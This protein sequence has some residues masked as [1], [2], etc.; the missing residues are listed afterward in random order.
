MKP[1][2]IIGLI[3]L[4]SCTKEHLYAE[5]EEQAIDMKHQLSSI[6]FVN[7]I[8]GYAVGGNIWSSGKIFSTSDAGEHWQLN[9]TSIRQLY[10]IKYEDETLLT[11]GIGEYF[12]QKNRQLNWQM[13]PSPTQEI[14]RSF[15]IMNNSLIFVGGVAFKE[16][17]IV[18]TDTLQNIL[19]TTKTGHELADVTFADEHTVFAVGYG[20]IYRSDDSGLQWQQLPISG[21][22][23][24]AVQFVTSHIGYIIGKTGTIL[25][26]D[27][28]GQNWK[29]LRDGAS[30][31]ISDKPFS[32]LHFITPEN[33]FVVGENG[34]CWYTM[35]GGKNWFDI[36]DLPKYDF[37]DI[38]VQGRFAWL[39]S[40]E[41]KIIRFQF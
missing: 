19:H 21:D 12:W 11:C 7:T 33:G 29:T 38:A 16:G 34:L 3:F 20:A 14:Y 40:K 32:N 25:R 5:W 1:L 9:E 13:Y 22:F 2:F 26:T 35:D 23:Y 15:A 37:T 8:E 17:V 6:M 36:P 39:T 4:V 27:N 18:T 30:V 10:A 41:G 28:G 24:V 31:W